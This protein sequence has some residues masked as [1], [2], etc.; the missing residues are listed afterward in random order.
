MK[1]LVKTVKKQVLIISIVTFL[2]LALIPS[3]YF[4]NQYQKAKK[5]LKTPTAAA[6]SEKQKTIARLGQLMVLPAGEEP[7]IATV[8]DR[9]KLKD[10]P[11][12]AKAK[13]GDVLIIYT[14]ARKMILFDPVADKIVDVVSINLGQSSVSPATTPAILRLAIFNGTKAVGL[15]KTAEKNLQG[16]IPNFAVT[17]RGNTKGDYEKTLVIDLSGNQNEL[18]QQIADQVKGEIGNLPEGETKPDAE[19]LIILGANYLQ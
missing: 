2:F 16:K 1:K 14:Q 5:Q 4:Y 6:D 8:S 19:I 10:Q 3:F 13:N 18:V 11:F 12:F 9:E 15:T 17:V 7:T